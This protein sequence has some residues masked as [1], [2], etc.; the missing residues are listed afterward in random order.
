MT[1]LTNFGLQTKFEEVK[2]LRNNLD[3][4]NQL[5]NWK[6]FLRFFPPRSSWVGRPEYDKIVM[7]KILFLQGCYGLSD[8][9]I[10]YQCHNRI[11]FQ[12]FL[13]FP[14]FIPDYSTIWRFREE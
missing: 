13:G 4:F 2:A 7:I 1:T 12:A 11:D 6:A 5:L 9:E 10:E 3:Q 14:E 8:E